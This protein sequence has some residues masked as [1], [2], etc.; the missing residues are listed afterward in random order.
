LAEVAPP[1]DGSSISSSFGFAI[2]ARHRHHLLLA[3]RERPGELA[4]ALVQER[5]ERVDTVE[6]L[7]RF[8]SVQAV[9]SS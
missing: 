5:E 3:A 9:S 2:N 8:V 1:I 7:L 4:A 6:I